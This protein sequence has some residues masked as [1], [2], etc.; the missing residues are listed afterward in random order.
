MKWI[1]GLEPRRLFVTGGLDPTFF[2]DGTG[3]I[4]F[5]TRRLDTV[6]ASAVQPD[7]KVVLVGSTD[8]LN[9]EGTDLA[10]A[11]L[12]PDATLDQSFGVT[13]TG[14]VGGGL[15]EIPLPTNTDTAFGVAIQSDGKIVVVGSVG[16]IDSFTG[17]LFGQAVVIRLTSAG[18]P[19]DSFGTNLPPGETG[20]IGFVFL[21]LST[22]QFTGVPNSEARA[23]GIQSTGKIVIGGAA[24]LSSSGSSSFAVA[25]LNTD[26]S[27][28]RSFGER[29]TGIEVE[30]IQ[31]FVTAV[32]GLDI[33]PD[34]K[35]VFVGTAILP[36]SDFNPAIGAFVT[37][38][39]TANGLTDFSFGDEGVA[40]TT[41]PNSG[42]ATVVAVASTVV[43]QPDG[44]TLVGG[45][46]LRSDA[47]GGGASRI[48]LVRYDVN[49]NPDPSFGGGSFSAPGTVE[50]FFNDTNGEA[51]LFTSQIRLR[52]DGSFF[53]SG[54]A[55]RAGSDNSNGSV[56]AR[57]RSNGALDNTF[58]RDGVILIFPEG[59]LFPNS[60]PG[61][62]NN[63]SR[64]AGA[65]VEEIPGGG[66]LILASGAGGTIN[67]ARL[68]ADGADL[69]TRVDK[70]R[71]GNFLGGTRS[72]AVVQLSNQ[73]SV[74][75]NGT[76]PISLRLSRDNT[77][78]S[79]DLMM[80]TVSSR[81]ALKPGQT[82]A[83][84]VRYA[85]PLGE[86]ANGTFFVLA[87]ANETRSVTEGSF[88]NNTS[89]SAVTVIV[90]PAFVDL[91]AE[92][93]SASATSVNRGKRVTF[94]IRL[95]NS[96]NINATGSIILQLLAS[97]DGTA[98]GDDLILIGARTTR[99]SLKPGQR[100]LR[101]TATIPKTAPTGNYGLIL[102]ID[103]T[104]L[105][106]RNPVRENALGTNLV[107]G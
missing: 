95:N 2:G 59:E 41:F 94:S 71:A 35:V 8:S 77:L 45:F 20:G 14:G 23:V 27:L 15:F 5:G 83:V 36:A 84:T 62:F 72:T 38:R 10:V 46:V 99:V 100:V 58:S 11:R 107:I 65:L 49:G 61:D 102:K 90:A 3:T 64:S 34:D 68:I 105:N 103:A 39:T 104:A 24:D 25:R 70:V 53:V 12:N 93:V 66:V 19:D 21:P 78:S 88:V 75:F 33:A 37:V 73:G 13:L 32:L 43:V 28:D 30:P 86:A 17:A 1:E 82:R 79:E 40:V 81:V 80:T 56:V 60:G 57:Y 101:F 16:E 106:G 74:P 31:G 48:A 51:N 85:Y 4:Q 26:G 50:T 92:F 9:D 6:F 63:A 91:G 96:G 29:G 22:D 89:A 98:S 69:I 97:T 44:K 67:A 54:R 7:G 47:F 42:N 52:A 87:N 55:G 18:T 76:V